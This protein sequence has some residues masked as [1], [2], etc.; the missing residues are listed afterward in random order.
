[1]DEKDKKK[2]IWPYILIICL[3]VGLVVVLLC[4]FFF[5]GSTKKTGSG[6]TIKTTQ[7]LTCEGNNIVYPILQS[8]NSDKKDM[9]IN[10][11]FDGD[12]VGSLSLVYKLYYSD[13]S[14]IDRASVN[15]RIIMNESFDG[16][17]L[18][19]D[20][21]GVTYSKLDDAMQFG[22]YAQGTDINGATA[23]YFMI[24]SYDSKLDKDFLEKNYNNEGLKC[25]AR[26]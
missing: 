15:A 14:S 8:I 18:G 1:M 6:S 5:S 20:A 11:I 25:T 4:I 23:K 7:S 22:L 17:G 26:Q 12:R 3:V 16:A 10:V 24:D 21:L 19:S 2:T 13:V 9:K